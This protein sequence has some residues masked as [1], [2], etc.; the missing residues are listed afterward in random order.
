MKATSLPS[1]EKTGSYL[2][3][4]ALM[5]GITLAG[6]PEY[7]AGA[8]T[9]R[10]ITPA[11]RITS[12]AAAIQAQRRDFACPGAVITAAVCAAVCPELVSLCNRFKSERRS[13]A[14]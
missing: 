10:Q 7:F 2:A 12:A 4:S 6:G 11:I 5:N 1:G 14:V 8:E 3:P 9:T 13:A